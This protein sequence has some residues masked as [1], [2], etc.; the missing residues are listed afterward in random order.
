MLLK[1]NHKIGDVISKLRKEKGWTQN[2]LAEKLQVSNKAVSKWESN[3]GDPSLEFLPTIAELFDVT[4]DYLMTGKEQKEKIVEINKLENDDYNPDNKLKDNDE[5]IK[6]CIHEGILNID[7]LLATNDYDLI[8]NNLYEYPINFIEIFSDMINKKDYKNLFRTAVDMGLDT[9]S[10]LKENLNKFSKN[11]IS[12]FWTN[13]KSAVETW[14]KRPVDEFKKVQ[15]SNFKYIK[16]WNNNGLI[17]EE[18]LTKFKESRDIIIQE[19]EFENAK[20]KITKNLTQ[21]FFE[22]ELK[23]NNVDRVVINLCVKLEAILKYDYRYDGDFQEM[24]SK[25][26]ET[27]NTHDDECNDYDPKT[28][29][30]LNKLR[31]YRN[32]MVHAN[33]TEESLT[34]NE[35]IYCINYICNLEKKGRWLWINIKRFYW[36]K[37]IHFAS[38]LRTRI[39]LFTML[40][41][42]I[43]TL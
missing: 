11:L 31:I 9:D 18:L 30:L 13:G 16:D 7:E 14:K 40:L 3:R 39:A 21:E 37:E 19:L 38:F 2:E 42:A 23:M 8:K 43:N 41:K 12:E 33:A 26:C 32:G 24:L 1:N 29:M 10:I 5:R 35:I 36:T 17:I 27:F 28:P 4:L 25:Y 34:R 22:G 20:N 15:E 6:L